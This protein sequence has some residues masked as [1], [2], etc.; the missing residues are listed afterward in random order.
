MPNPQYIM[1]SAETNYVIIV[2]IKNS[3]ITNYNYMQ[4]EDSINK[5]TLADNEKLI[6]SLKNSELLTVELPS[7][8]KLNSLIS[9]KKIVEALSFVEKECMIKGSLEHKK[10]EKIY[11]NQLTQAVEALINNNKEHAHM[12][13]DKF[14]AIPSKKVEID[15]LYKAFDYFSRFRAL[16]LDK[17]YALAYAMVS[18]YPAFKYTPQYIKMEKVWKEIF[19]DAQRQMMLGRNDIAKGILSEYMTTTSKRP[20]IKFILNHNKHFLEFLKA[21]EHKEYKK[22]YDIA[23]ENEIFSQIP[24][25]TA[26]NTEINQKIIHA[27]N[28]IN[29]G[30]TS[31]ALTEL[32]EL[33]YISHIEKKVSELNERCINV[34][35]LQSAYKDN[36]FKLCYNIL[37]SND[38]LDTIELSTFL[39]KH[40]SKLIIKCEEFALM[41]DI[42]AIKEKLWELL[43]VKSRSE[44]IGDLL[45]VSYHTKIKLLINKKSFKKAELVIYAYLDTFGLDSEINTL[46][47]KFEKISSLKLAIEDSSIKEIKRDDWIDSKFT[48]HLTKT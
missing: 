16:V 36:D 46:K 38:S 21:I 3:K 7:L 39:E 18:K 31:K 15:A 13:I 14:R 6:I 42:K 20:L 10:L 4:F 26:L 32:N 24:T 9:Q 45:R 47:T 8:G 34:E 28:L 23:T 41:G 29:I 37:D 5:I 33:K 22:V 17:K 27:E 48:Q 25:Y 30:N 40:W 11:E 44:K 2:D 1:V 35:K 19:G 12:L 43:L